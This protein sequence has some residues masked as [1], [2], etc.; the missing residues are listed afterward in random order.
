[1]LD[2][3]KIINNR[4]MD[5]FV[6]NELIIKCT[7][8]ALNEGE[9]GKNAV[10]NSESQLYGKGGVLDSL[11]LVRVIAELEDEIYAVTQKNITLADEKAMS[12]KSS[13]FRSVAALSEY[14]SS[15]L[16]LEG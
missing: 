3:G 15:L 6:L 12:Q 8:D 9:F 14:I 16:A 4:G 1:M 5:K 10:V 2:A 11:G 13:P 7:Q